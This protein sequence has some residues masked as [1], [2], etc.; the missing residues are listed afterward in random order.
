MCVCVCVCVLKSREF[1]SV[2]IAEKRAA[3]MNQYV[4]DR[5]PKRGR[6]TAKR[7]TATCSKAGRESRDTHMRRGGQ[8][9]AD[10]TSPP[11]LSRASR[12]G[13]TELGTGAR[14]SDSNQDILVLR[15][16]GSETKT[17]GQNHRH[18]HHLIR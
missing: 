2:Q 13:A 8:P 14:R 12:A 4:N 10:N 3:A 5:E 1:E 9:R 16:K 11:G 6:A 18:H 7:V 15:S 17:R